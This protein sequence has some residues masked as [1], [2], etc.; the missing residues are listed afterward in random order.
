MG[1]RTKSWLTAHSPVA[2]SWMATSS[3]VASPVPSVKTT[4]RPRSSAMT[5]TSPPRC[6]NRRTLMSPLVMIW[7]LEM[8]V[9]R[10]IDRNTRRL[11]GISTISPTTLGGSSLR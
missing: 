10:P 2:D 3:I 8:L 11:P 6:S 9:T 1:R 5:R 4:L 7:P